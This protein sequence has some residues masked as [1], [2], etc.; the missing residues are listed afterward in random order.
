MRLVLDTNVFIGALITKGTP[1]DHLYQAW[2]N[3]RFDL[4]TSRAQLEELARV[5]RY[6]RLSRFIDAA[7]AQDLLTNVDTVAEVFT[8]LPEINASPDPDD[9]LILA[10]AIAGKADM[11]V[12]GDKQHMLILGDVEGIPIVTPRDALKRIDE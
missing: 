7:E 4:V 11:I 12:S 3:Q 2:T 5:L 9:N 1:P 10:T 6:E 8:D